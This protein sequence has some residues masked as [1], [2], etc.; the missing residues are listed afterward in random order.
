VTVDGP[1][2]PVYAPLATG[3]TSPRRTVSAHERCTSSASTIAASAYFVMPPGAAA[4]RAGMPR[5]CAWPGPA[6]TGRW[7]AISLSTSTPLPAA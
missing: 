4:A 7:T 6:P 1:D 2:T 5:S 3:P